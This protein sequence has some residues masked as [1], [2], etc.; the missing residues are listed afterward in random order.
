MIKTYKVVAMIVKRKT[1]YGGESIAQDVPSKQVLRE[2]K[3]FQ[4]LMFGWHA[5]KADDKASKFLSDAL[6]QAKYLSAT[7]VHSKSQFERNAEEWRARAKCVKDDVKDPFNVLASI[8]TFGFPLWVYIVSKSEARKFSNAARL[9]SQAEKFAQTG[10]PYAVM[11]GVGMRKWMLKKLMSG[12]G[13]A[14]G[15]NTQVESCIGKRY[16][17][18]DYSHKITS[19]G[20]LEV[21]SYHDIFRHHMAVSIQYGTVRVYDGSLESLMYKKNESE[22]VLDIAIKKHPSRKN[23]FQ[24]EVSCDRIYGPSE[25]YPASMFDWVLEEACRYVRDFNFWKRRIGKT[26]YAMKYFAMDSDQHTEWLNFTFGDG[27]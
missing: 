5:Q 1:Q 24:I 27:S 3:M 15:K 11:P 22:Q 17:V 4:K 19:L 20:K 7:H 16:P 12:L 14:A 26:N 9:L 10:N 25:T 13:A 6:L 8:A 2:I 21:G 18:F 23:E